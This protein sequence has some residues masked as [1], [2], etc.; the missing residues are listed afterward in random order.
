MGRGYVYTCLAPWFGANQLAAPA[1]RL[2]EHVIAPIQPV[3]IVDSPLAGDQLTVPMPLAGAGAPIAVE[4][5]P[6]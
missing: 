5:P 4:V 1:W 2:L 3:A 6:A